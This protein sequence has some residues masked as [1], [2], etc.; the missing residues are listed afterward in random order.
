MNDNRLAKTVRRPS[1]GSRISAM[2]RRLFRPGPPVVLQ[3][4]ATECGAACLSWILTFLGR[5]TAV[6]QVRKQLGVGRDGV[7]PRVFVEAA[8]E[9]Q[10]RSR[11]FSVPLEHFSQVQ[12]PAVVHWRFNH[13]VVVERWSEKGAAIF[14]PTLGR[15]RVSPREFSEGFT[16]IVLTFEPTADFEP[17]G[18]LPSAWKTFLRP[19]VGNKLV[20]RLALQVLTASLVLQV[21]GLASPFLI[22]LL[23]DYV[24]PM[25]GVSLMQVIGV[26]LL[27]VVLSQ[28]LMS[29]LRNALLVS[30]KGRFDEETLLGL[31]GHLLKLPFLF[32][33]Q[34]TS[35]DLLTRLG[36][37]MMVREVL[38]NQTLTMILDAGLTITYLA[39]LFAYAPLFGAVALGLGLL[40]LFFI[41]LTVNR[42][43]DLLQ[44][45]LAAEAEFQSFSV[46]VLKSIAVIKASAAE[47]L[48][49][50]YW[51]S[52]FHRQLNIS[53]ERGYLTA[54]VNAGLGG[55][56]MLAPLALL[57]LGAL[58]VIE[59][60]MALGTMLALNSIAAAILTPL[61][62]LVTNGHQL[63]LVGAHLNRVLDVLEA[64]PEARTGSEQPA[65]DLD[66][67]V[68]LTN[69]HYR[70]GRGSATILSDLSITIE[71]GQKVAIVG[72]SGS[73][74]S[75][76]GCLLLGLFEP[77]EGQI[78]YDGMPFSDMD[79]HQ[80]R[81]QFGVVL[82]EP[83]LF[84]GPIRENIALNSPAMPLEEIE[85][86]ARLAALEEDIQRM[87]MRY[88]TWIGEGGSGLSG[89]QRQ[90]LALARALAT[91]PTLLLLDE[92]TSHLDTATEAIVDE[93][94]SRLSCTRIIIAHR[95]S[96]VRNAD[97]ILV[98]DHG[99]IVEQGTHDV[100]TKKN[101]LYAALA[102]SQ[103]TESTVRPVAEPSAV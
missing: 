87:P 75:T 18:R 17:G 94:L 30:L 36:S 4:T 80:V 77:T 81:R 6:A 63:H 98:L 51:S 37:T 1:R 85:E 70:Y 26:G 61:S 88:D 72:R 68:Q 65:P 20:R 7:R 52:L 83:L 60:Q 42:T 55:I 58:Q 53:L 2:W 29:Y 73:G 76:L 22:K 27:L 39:I 66:G 78:F 49:L 33:A 16:G 11:C 48:T 23:V 101:G 93:N 46:Q 79:V 57:W 86:A 50:K 96:T 56:R 69:V 44:R 103:A 82:Q 14:D 24:L 9:F 8:R 3:S 41:F 38:A 32:Y 64:E 92:A 45:N 91:R 47:D 97:L 84:S 13:F 10:L 12:L 25:Q 67:H 34:R 43:R 54:F 62:Q 31:L 35:G 5:P 89:G 28:T 99:Q 100:L 59:G 90:R 71:P 102:Q 74:K 95:L 21:L 40:Q 15:R 19:L